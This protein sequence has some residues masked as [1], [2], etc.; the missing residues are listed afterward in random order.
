MDI[1]D[2]AEDWLCEGEPDLPTFLLIHEQRRDY[3]WEVQKKVAST[4]RLDS[5]T[6]PPKDSDINGIRWL[7]EL[8]RRQ[9]QNFGGNYLLKPCF[10]AEE[11]AIFS[12]KII[13][14]LLNS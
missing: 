10:V 13:F 12:I 7:P 4:E 3:F 14:I 1:F 6:L 11:T 8:F 2:F 9:K 5:S